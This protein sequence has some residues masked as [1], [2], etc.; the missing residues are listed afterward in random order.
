MYFKDIPNI[1][2][3]VNINNKEHLKILKDITYNIR[4]KK[5]LLDNISLY[6]DYDLVKGD[7]P[8]IIAHKIYGS[9]KF[10]WLIMLANEKYHWIKDFPL[11]DEILQQYIDDKY[12][13]TQNDIRHYVLDGYIV[14]S[15][16][17]GATPVTNYDYEASLNES[18]RRIKVIDPELLP[19]I[20]KEMGKI[21]K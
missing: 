10:H 16:T 1:Y 19:I 6:Y 7:T 21:F 4:L 5:N 12:G 17:I 8:E 9:T 2:Y 18:K 14:S 20:L 3:K 11:D 15:N 13:E